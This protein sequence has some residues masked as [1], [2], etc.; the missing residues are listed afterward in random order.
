MERSDMTERQ[1]LVL[2]FIKTY[3]DM[4]GHAPSMQDIATGLGMKSRS[5]IHRIIHDLRKNGYLRLK[6]TQARTLKVMDRSVQE[7]VSL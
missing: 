7:A 2:E 3:W 5:N 4:K 6:P 1:K